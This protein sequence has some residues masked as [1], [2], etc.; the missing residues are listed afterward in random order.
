MVNSSD[1]QENLAFN[2]ED[3]ALEEVM[4]ESGNEVIAD[5]LN[6]DFVTDFLDSSGN[7][8]ISHP[9][10]EDAPSILAF[11]EEVLEDTSMGSEVNQPNSLVNDPI[12]H[13]FDEDAP[14]ILAFTE[15]EIQENPLESTVKSSQT[16]DTMVHQPTSQSLTNSPAPALNV[17]QKFE[18]EVKNKNFFEAFMTVV[19]EAAQLK[20]L[21]I[22]EDENDPLFEDDLSKVQGQPGKRMATLVEL[23]SGD[24]KN[25]VGSRF[26]EHPNYQQILNF[27]REQVGEGQ[28]MIEKNISNLRNMLMDLL[29]QQN[30]T[31]NSIVN[32]SIVEANAAEIDQDLRETYPSNYSYE[33][34]DQFRENSNYPDNFYGEER[35]EDPSFSL[36]YSQEEILEDG[37]F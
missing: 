25:I 37:T 36:P 18:E 9:F 28:E 6:E 19:R 10:D 3:D 16:A 7:D 30:N 11:T 20:V 8:P 27:H 2:L 5:S 32:S 34:R 12:S 22:V 35:V 14:S 1:W 26:L 24:I 21:T 15:E 31:E 33:M 13:P 23:L 29:D 17:Q 4:E